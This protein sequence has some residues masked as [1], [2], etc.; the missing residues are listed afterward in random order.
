MEIKI[1]ELLDGKGT[2]HIIP[3]FWQHGENEEI[4]REYVA[5]IQNSNIQEMCLESRPHPDF[6]GEKWWHDMDIIMDEARKR[7]MKVWLLDDSHY[8]TGYANGAFID[9]SPEVRKQYIHF[10]T[11]DV[12]GPTPEASA[13]I[14]SEIEKNGK[15]ETPVVFP[16]MTVPQFRHFD[17]DRILKVMAYK[18]MK[19]NVIGEGIDITDCLVNGRLKWNVPCGMW[20]IYVIYF[21]QNGGGRTDYMNIASRASV[22]VLLDKVYE[23]VYERYGE[24]FGKTF[25]GFFSDEPLVGNCTELY[26]DHT[27]IGRR[28]MPIPW[29]D[30]ME[31]RMKK[32]L[33]KNWLEMFPMLWDSGDN[34]ETTAKVRHIYMDEF[35][36]CVKDN[37]SMQIGNWCQE[38]GVMYIG[39]IVED[40]NRS[41]SL[42]YIGDYHRALGGQHMAGIDVIGGGVVPAGENRL[43]GGRN[44]EDG[45][46]YHFMLGK[47][48]TGLAH[49]DPRK[50][51]R[52]MLELFGAYGWNFGVR[53]MLYLANHFLV[54]GVNYFVPHAFSPKEFP[55]PDCPPHFYARGE[56]PQYKH[57]GKLM[58]YMQRISHLIDGGT[59]VI[60]VALLHSGMFSW[61]DDC[62]FSQIPAR[63][64]AEHQI[65][66]EVI[67]PDV[68]G[69]DAAILSD[70]RLKINGESFG[71]LIIPQ[72]KTITKA[73]V[74]F[75][76]R[77]KETGF[78][79][80]FINKKPQY[81]VDSDS[82]AHID[83]EVVLLQNLISKIR[84][85][86][87]ADVSIQPEC[88]SI[89]YYQYRQSEKIYLFSNESMGETYEGE[90]FVKTCGN[91]YGYDAMENQLYH[92]RQKQVK[93][94]TKLYLRLKPY[95]IV[96]VAFGE[97]GLEIGTR[98]TA[99]E[100]VQELSDWT[101]SLGEARKY[102]EFYECFNVRNLTDIGEVYSDFGGYIRY[103]ITFRTETTDL[104]LKID[105]AYECVDVWCNDFF[106]GTKLAPEY[107]FDISKALRPGKNYLRIEVATTLQRKVQAMEKEE[108]PFMKR[109]K[110]LD[111]IGIIGPV[112]LCRRRSE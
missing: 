45:D 26:D 37:F 62:M 97:E 105:D 65:D 96:I 77:A 100:K 82:N 11:I 17:T 103:E 50:K 90:I 68:L 3:F 54:R 83:G 93:N 44:Q 10:V 48:G 51:G 61:T 23:P 88:D 33:G 89:R 99:G 64:M 32:R 63:E 30:E 52:T 59:P 27:F 36:K 101:V 20:R 107:I 91:A 46:F 34:F 80:W 47:L 1:R 108:D 55:D 14:M 111:P 78:P 74:D 57:F 5:V 2:S 56:N 104:M 25:A 81:V 39:H 92:I 102:P 95:E 110:I 70:G 4:L 22:K 49:T 16:G 29:C 12:A 43:P 76:A 66:Y 13:N 40:S 38:H 58:A 106:V 35:T 109:P 84:R 28:R 60:P 9:A 18:V 85:N 73:V 67:S 42:N 94:G 7:H 53:S 98:Y 72:S 21:T 86:G 6:L 19:G 87:F 71:A 15:T 79:V 69:T 75:A 41:A 8:P 24:D 31:E 112:Y